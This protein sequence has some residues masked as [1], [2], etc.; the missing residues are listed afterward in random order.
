MG[1]HRYRLGAAR[2]RSMRIEGAH[3]RHR[4]RLQAT[5]AIRPAPPR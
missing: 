5:A 3:Q 2:D 1:L 4:G